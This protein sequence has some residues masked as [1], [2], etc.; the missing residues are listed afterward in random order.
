MG[1]ISRTVDGSVLGV[2]FLRLVAGL[3]V[4]N[5]A[6]RYLRACLDSLLGFC[7]E[8]RVLDDGSTDEFREI[9]W[10]DDDRVQIM[11]NSEPV[12]FEHEGRARNQLLRW[13]LEARPT[14][15]LAIDADEFVGD[16]VKLRG[17]CV[18]H[19]AS[20]RA[21]SLCMMEV[22]KAD[23]SS[24]W[25]RED[26]GW[27]SHEVPVVWKV[28]RE[29][30]R[31]WAIADRALAC[32]RVPVAVHR[33]RAVY[34]G[35]E[36]LHMGWCNPAERQARYDRYAK[37]DGGRFHASAHLQSIMWPDARVRLEQQ[38]WP[39]GDWGPVVAS[40]SSAR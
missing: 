11:R 13:T 24:L 31:G 40:C 30:G 33:Q 4:R 37:H 25:T 7:D 22:W 20:V 34:A 36:L 39:P 19:G 17:L 10:Y 23:S 5:E 38:P 27:C 28:P 16:G 26:G 12:F 6:H 29:R 9:G 8:I 15:V 2:V 14:H 35:T 1:E 32:G 3:I 21:F 18:E